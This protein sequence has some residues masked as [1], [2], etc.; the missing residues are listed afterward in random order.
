MLE[1]V[2]L[3]VLIAVTSYVLSE[4]V[5][6]LEMKFSF[7]TIDIHKPDRRHV[8][9]SGGIALMCSLVTSV[10]YLSLTS[11]LSSLVAAY[12]ASALVAGLI[13]L[14]DDLT[15][16][17][18]KLKLLLF[19]LPA[20]LPVTLQLYDPYPYV[21]GAGY[22]RLTMLYPLAVIALFNVMANA[23][24]MSDTHNGIIV[25]VFLIFAFLLILSTNLP[26]PKPLDGYDTL[27][28][29]STA[30]LLGYLPLNFYPARMLNGN[31]GSHLIGSLVAALIVTSRR[32]FLAIMLLI[33]QILNGYLILLTAGLKSK[34]RIERPTKI[35]EDGVI[36][37]NCSPRASITFVRLLVLEEGLRERELI[38]EYLVLQVISSAVS[39]VLYQAMCMI[40][41]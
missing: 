11:R 34:E 25:S 2:L 17:S 35:T 13:G 33:P 18:V 39:L 5:Y 32:E 24:N 15:R 10:V 3:A 38:K 4:I 22:L 28:A 37:P 27:L 41:I 1:L 31:S 6:R 12:I 14:I 36:R 7:T 21:P 19:C 23:F 30:S 8:A 16:L 20:L 26:G 40:R 9:R 29:V